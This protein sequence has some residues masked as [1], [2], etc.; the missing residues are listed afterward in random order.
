MAIQIAPRD[1]RAYTGAAAIYR[2]SKD[3]TRSE[4]MLRRAAEID[5]SN[6]AIRRQLGAVVALNLV[7][8]SQEAK[9]L[10]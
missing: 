7:H 6:L 8:T 5:P 3:Y 2:E 9:T 10:A 1:I 4:D